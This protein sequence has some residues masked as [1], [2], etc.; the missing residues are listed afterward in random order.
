MINDIGEL[1]GRKGR[2]GTLSENIRKGFDALGQLQ[3]SNHK[4]RTAYLI[5]QKPY[6]TVGG[7]TFIHDMLSRSGFDNIFADRKRI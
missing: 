6:M 1:T 5:W 7:D 3:T 4:P 2:A